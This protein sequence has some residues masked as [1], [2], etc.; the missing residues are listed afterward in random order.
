MQILRPE[1]ARQ[2]PAQFCWIDQ[3]L[4]RENF[5]RHVE[6]ATWALYLVLITVAESLRIRVA[7][8]DR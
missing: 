8:H 4:V 7:F 2:V 1:P 6:P 3:R 5:L